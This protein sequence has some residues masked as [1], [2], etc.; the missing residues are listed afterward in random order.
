[1]VLDLSERGEVSQIT[2]FRSPGLFSNFGLPRAM[3]PEG[4][5]DL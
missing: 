3:D 5:P 4:S 1:V 2:S